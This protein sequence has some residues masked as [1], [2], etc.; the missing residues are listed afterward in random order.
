V[1]FRKYLA[2]APQ[3]LGHYSSNEDP[4]VWLRPT[5]KAN[6]DDYYE[7]LLVYM[8]D[9]LPIGKD[10]H[11]ILNKLNKHFTLK[12]EWMK[13]PD[14][15][16]RF[17][18]NLTPIANATKAQGQSSSHYIHIATKETKETKETRNFSE[19]FISNWIKQD[20]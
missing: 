17:R 20:S 7:Y 6:G 18:T 8:D 1:S 19:I 12:P 2:S 13:P 15:Y 5:T 3:D 10:P 4:V 14:D 11:V 9:M 16:L